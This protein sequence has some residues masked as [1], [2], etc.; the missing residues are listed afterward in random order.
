MNPGYLPD[1]T[2]ISSIK[3]EKID[4]LGPAYSMKSVMAAVANG[5]NH[6]DYLER[7]VRKEM[8][9]DF[10]KASLAAKEAEA[11]FKRHTDSMLHAMTTLQQT[12]KKA[13]GGIRSAADDLQSGIS[14]IEKQANFANLERYVSLLERAATA[15][16]LLADLESTGRLDKIAGALK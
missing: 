1:G 9:P 8:T 6:G 4:H 16:Q 2:D 11:L 7:R 10:E 15:M 14:R 13:S 12:A 5:I 3:P